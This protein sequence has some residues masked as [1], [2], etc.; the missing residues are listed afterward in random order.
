M[1]DKQEPNVTDKQKA[2]KAISGAGYAV[3]LLTRIESVGVPQDAVARLAAAYDAG[4]DAEVRAVVAEH[5][6]HFKATDA[7]ADP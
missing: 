1:T 3:A 4:D 5:Y 6:E 7:D 2:Q